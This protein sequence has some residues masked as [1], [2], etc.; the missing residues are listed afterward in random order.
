M[1]SLEL[2][3]AVSSTTGGVTYN[4][5]AYVAAAS[6]SSVGQPIQLVVREQTSTGGA[7]VST[8]PRRPP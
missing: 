1:Y 4:A 3:P 7:V 2:N 8:A 6:A 5:A